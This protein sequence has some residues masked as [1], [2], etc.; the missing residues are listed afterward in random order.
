MYETARLRDSS[1]ATLYRRIMDASKDAA[2]HQMNCCMRKSWNEDD[3]EL[4]T[5]TFYGLMKK[6]AGYEVR[7]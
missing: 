7:S 1:E 5:K 6:Y 3:H 2:N 4:F